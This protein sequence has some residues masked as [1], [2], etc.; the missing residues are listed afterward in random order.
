[1]SGDSM[2]GD[3]ILKS[4][5][6]GNTWTHV[7]GD[8][9]EGVSTAGL[10]V[11]PTNPNH[12]YVAIDRGRGGARRTTPAEHS[13]YGIWES[14]DGGVTWTLLKEAKSELDGA[15]DIEIDPQNSDH[16]LCVVLGRRD[17]Q[18]HGR[19]P[20]LGDDDERAPGRRRLSG[21]LDAILHLRVASVGFS[22]RRC[23]TRAST[24]ND[25]GR[26]ACPRPRVEVDERRREL[27]SASR[28]VRN[29][30]GLR[31]LRDAVL[32]RQRD[33]SRSDQSRTSCLLPGS[34]GYNLSPPSGGVFRSTDGGQTW[35]NLGWDQHPD[36]HALALDPTNT[37]HVL[38][39][40]DGGVWYS[41]D[42][43]G[44]PNG[45]ASPLSAVDWQDL[46]G[47]VDPAS[48]AVTHRTG[49]QISQFTSVA[50]VPQV[51]R[52]ADSERFWGGTQDNGTLRK[53]VNSATWF[54]VAS[55]DGGQAL[56]DPTTDTCT[57]VT[58]PSCFVYGTYFGVSPVSLY[59]RRSRVL[60]QRVHRIG[61]QPDRPLG[62]L[63]PV[64]DEPAEHEP[65]LPG[66]LSR[67]PHGQRAGTVGLVEADQPR[68]DD[69]LYRD[70]SERRTQLHD[71]GDRRRRW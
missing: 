53:S 45:T 14:K 62:L 3:G 49:L 8:Y 41:T 47:T 29:Q 37:A 24:T 25:I 69:R 4:T 64:G 15:T 2:F 1:M 39:G 28:R 46:N 54:D 43:G 55:G 34:F 7:S 36:F 20:K 26:L 59:R 65:A 51:P 44:R 6:G 10:A 48:G 32:L 52:G 68:P 21:R 27:D 60:Q 42:R 67:V 35:V 23:S 5:D 38:I 58:A 12:L 17:V 16:A 19:R 11:D 40:S 66:H 70:R 50:N 63:P 71:L 56:V 61:D 9:F 18:E 22:H 57:P 30:L 31:L 33:R 13:R